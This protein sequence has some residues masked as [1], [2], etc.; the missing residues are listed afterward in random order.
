MY[1]LDFT[2]RLKM[3]LYG[4]TFLCI[5]NVLDAFATIQTHMRRHKC[6][7]NIAN[8]SVKFWPILLTCGHTFG[9]AHE[10][11]YCP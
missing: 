2:V 5:Y 8:A 9:Q 4:K 6:I 3:E 10:H 1:I 11:L 7:C